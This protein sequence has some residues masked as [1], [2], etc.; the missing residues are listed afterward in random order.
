MNSLSLDHIIIV[1]SDLGLAVDQFQQA[2]FSVIPGG[3]H[4]GNLTHNALIPFAD[5]TYLELLATTRRST[6]SYFK[7][8]QKLRLLDVFT[9]GETEISRR[10]IGNIACGVGMNDFV[11]FSPDLTHEI[12]LIRKAG[13]EISDPIPGGRI[14]PDGQQIS[15]RTAVPQLDELPF[16]I[17]DLTPR[18]LRNPTVSDEF[19]AN[20]IYSIQGLSIL[21]SS[22]VESTTHYQS[23]LG[24]V[25]ASEVK[26]PQPGTKNIQFNMGIRFF[27]LAG[28]LPGTTTLQKHLACRPAKPLGIYFLSADEKQGNLSS[29]T[30]TQDKGV[31]LSKSHRFI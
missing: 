6:F 23:L 13:L 4:S 19:H 27:S 14:R 7:V 3:V 12:A 26:Y 18:E 15:W 9:R 1:V 10:L 2:G 20:R 16:L 22:I 31:N 29:L 25:P 5:G 28:I 17:D 30:Y 21:V 24:N 8:L 11:L